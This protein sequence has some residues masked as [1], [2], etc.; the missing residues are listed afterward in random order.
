MNASHD[1][2]FRRRH[3]AS[4]ILT[5]AV[6]MIW[7]EVGRGVGPATENGFFQDFDLDEI[8]EKDFARIEKKMRW[9]ANKNFAISST[10][11]DE[12]TARELFKTEKFKLAL[13]DEIAEK[14]ENFSIYYFAPRGAEFDPAKV[15]YFDLCAG[16]H[17]E[18]TGEVGAFKLTR[19]SG[20]YFR[21]DEKDQM[22]TR[23][24]GVAFETPEILEKYFEDLKEAEK[25]DHRKL[26]KELEL[27]AFDAD[28]GPGLPLWLPA[29]TAVCDAL[30]NLAQKVEQKFGYLRV[31]SPHIAKG[32]LYEKTGHL[33]LYAES[34]FPPMELDGEKYYLKSMN[35]PHHHKIFAATPK[36]Y[37]DLPLRLA[38]YGHCYRF[39]DSGSLF[40]LMRVRSLTMN[41]AHIYCT[42]EQF[43]VEFSKV[44]E[45]YLF[46]FRVFGIEKFEMRLSKHDPSKLGKK[47]VNRPELWEKTEG[48]VRD[49][50]V[51]SGV[52]FFEA[53]DEAAFYGPKIDVEITSAIGRNFT[54]ATNQ[55]DFD[56]PEKLGLFYV[57]QKGEKQ[58][59][60]CIH[61]APLST[62]ERM[63]GFLTE[64]FAGA[65]PAWLAPVQVAV[66]PVSE[67]H[68]QAAEKVFDS[69]KSAGA[70]VNF[71]DFREKL[72]AR[73]AKSQTKKI[74]F[75]VILGDRECAENFLTVRKYGEKTDAKMTTENLLEFLKLPE[76]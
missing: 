57:D 60:L 17:L 74:P 20:A 58:V 61:R 19:L 64:H 38:E 41:D 12:K 26:G 3:T 72:G 32:N 23:I 46:Y 62:H 39:E 56:V 34:M 35:C 40:G 25:R 66:L 4:H 43:E 7:P 65:F 24:S 22:L 16:P 69:L 52:R 8:S 14:G 15:F 13:I 48:Q 50:L 28:V 55:L 36:S 67:T 45:M 42:P 6:R 75:S 63:V 29:G 21:G 71:F 47:Y 9:I 10:Q 68:Q 31:R 51:K 30:E 33:K 53:A 2:E 44:I 37:R 27:F 70:R 73:I 76:I 18:S 1:L 11:V 54:L 59:P 5:A 49:A